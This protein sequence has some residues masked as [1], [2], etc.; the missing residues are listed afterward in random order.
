MTLTP[1]QEEQHRAG[2]EQAGVT[3]V[4]ED[5]KQ[6]RIPP[7]YRYS[8]SRWLAEKEREE[9]LRRDASISEQME[10]MRRASSAAERQAIAAERA[11]TRATIA[12]VIAIISMAVT[13]A[14][15]W[16]THLDVNK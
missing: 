2:M 5:L 12:L 16:T 15:I 4:R 14:G 10:L 11:N 3:N 6:G 8:A 13:I 1:D 9:N 7:A